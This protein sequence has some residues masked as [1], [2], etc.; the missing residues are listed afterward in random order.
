[1]HAGVELERAIAQG[2]RDSCA[3]VFFVTPN[4]V[5]E[6]YLA[7]EV[8]YA[9]AEKR[10]KGTKFA[11]ITLVYEGDGKKGQ[12]PDLLA[13]YVWKEPRNDLEAIRELIRA[14]PV[15][16]GDVYWRRGIIFQSSGP[17]RKAAQ[18]AHFHVGHHQ[19]GQM[20]FCRGCGK[21]IHETAVSC[22]HCGATQNITAK[23]SQN[24]LGTLWLP[25]PS[26]ILG[27]IVVLA[28]FDESSWDKDTYLGIFTCIVA[29]ITLGG[30]GI[31]TQERGRGMSIAGIVLGVVGLLGVIGRAVS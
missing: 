15:K 18:A 25:V 23:S 16:V 31:S 20:V 2:F 29:A 11:I 8:N 5:D 4:Y 17:A 3:A 28:L 26:L 21:E 12:V 13:P 27:I 22:P 6:Q 24:Q 10:R 14:L 7:T 9:I 19:G 1:M 30:F